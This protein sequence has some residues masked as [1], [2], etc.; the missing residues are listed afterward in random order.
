MRKLVVLLVLPFVVASTCF[1]QVTAG[2]VPFG[3]TMDTNTVILQTDSVN[4]VDSA[5]FDIN[6]DG[7]NDI[8][9]LLYAGNTPVDG[10]VSLYIELLDSTIEHAIDSSYANWGPDWKSKQYNQGQII[11]SDST[12]WGN[13]LWTTVGA[14]GGW[15]PI[16]PFS[17]THTFLAIKKNSNISWIELSYNL[18][19]NWLYWP[20]DTI[21][22]TIHQIVT[23]CNSYS[24]ESACDSL[25]SPSGDQIWNLTGNYTDTLS[26]INGDDS[27]VYISLNIY[28]VET[29][30]TATADSLIS[31]ATLASYQWLDCNQGLTPIAADTSALFVP[32]A[33][34]SYAVEV[35][36]NG[37]I[38]TSDCFDIVELSIFENVHENQVEL[39]PNPVHKSFIVNLGKEYDQ[40]TVSIMDLNGRL[41]QRNTF[42]DRAIINLNLDISPGLYT[43]K[44]DFGFKQEFIKIVKL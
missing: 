42:V 14:Q 36:Q 1:S 40:I 44:V 43:V 39:F 31:L 9:F 18:N 8:R 29:A 25:I 12:E 41:I 10:P 16:Q 23:H 21:V 11:H 3:L 13:S 6:C 20:E 24:N 27:I 30:V 32:V 2:I 28:E 22:A 15:S 17:A 19:N 7:V 33:N 38:D 26:D 35:T 4:S 37:C 34:G 5:L